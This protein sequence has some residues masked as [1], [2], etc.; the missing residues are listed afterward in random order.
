MR[1][2]LIA[3]EVLFREFSHYAALAEHPI[4][5]DFLPQGLHQEPER[6]RRTVQE[7]I[8]KTEA[9]HGT[10]E[11]DFHLP[12]RIEY[13]GII[14]G[15]GLCSN[16]IIGLTSR[17]IP[18]I[19]PRG[20]DCITLLLGSKER[21][22]EYFNSHRGV[23]WY[24]A[25]WI[26]R[27]IPPG[28]ERYEHLFQNYVEKYGEDNAAYLM[29]MEQNWFKEYAWATYIDWGFPQSDSYR[30]VTQEAAQFLGWNYDE[31]PGDPSLI[32]KLVNGQWDADLFLRVEPGQTV[33]P[34]YDD[35]IICCH[36][37]G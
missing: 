28:R 19:I 7:A 4:D 12:R 23:Y 15:Y 1:L 21:Y 18:L 11:G 2:K 16:G 20:H 9:R 17:K 22:Q 35:L 3:C 30:R 14:L 34:S 5:V 24:S 25:G 29:E 27:T 8:D 37:R 26:E 32:A 36:S 33:S 10:R 31:L 13:D 6:L